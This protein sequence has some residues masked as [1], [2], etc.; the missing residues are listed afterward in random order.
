MSHDRLRFEV[1]EA[2]AGRRLDRFLGEQAEGRSRS[3]LRRLILDGRVQIDG[4]V[5]KKPSHAL[6]PGTRIVVDLPPSP[7][8]GPLP[9]S[10][11]LE[12]LHEDPHLVVVLKPAGMVVHPGHGRAS[13]TLVNALLGRDILLSPTGAPDRPGIVHRL[14]KGTSGVVVVA[15]SAEAHAGLA[16]AFA[17]RRVTKQYR[18]LVWGHPKPASGSIE[19]SI[20]R[21]RSQPL[22]MAVRGTRG[23]TR[24]AETRYET[25]EILPG[26]ALLDLWPRTGRTHQIRVHLQSIHH[27]IVGDEQ[28]GGRAWRGVQDPL[29]RKAIREFDRLALHAAD[30]SFSHPVTG[31]DLRF[32]APLP[33]EFEALLRAL[34]RE[35]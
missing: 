6:R 22:K 10:I 30:L 28:Y 19:R 18:A 11:H 35:P 5:V 33:P 14:D 31:V 27:P 25:K 24:V 34:R 15:K 20:G 16:A 1:P 32:H 3:A 23:R 17:E 4:L 7:P 21:S 26:F 8:P 2:A 9:E 13:G 12:L 29:K